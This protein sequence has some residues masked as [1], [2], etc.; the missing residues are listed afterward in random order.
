MAEKVRGIRISGERAS[1]CI[2]THPDAVQRPSGYEDTSGYHL[3]LFG[4][5]D[6]TSGCYSAHPNTKEEATKRDIRISC[7]ISGY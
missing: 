5:E 2:K 4:Y 6:A 1:E 3:R 7:S